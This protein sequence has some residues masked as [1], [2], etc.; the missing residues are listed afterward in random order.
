MSEPMTSVQVTKDGV[1]YIE[2]ATGTLYDDPRKPN[3]YIIVHGGIRP[4]PL[5]KNQRYE[6]KANVDEEPRVFWFYCTFTGQQAEFR[7]A[8]EEAVTA[9]EYK[10]VED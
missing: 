10:S 5:V 1:N 9:G 3:T 8:I 2:N 7:V 6:V 4:Q